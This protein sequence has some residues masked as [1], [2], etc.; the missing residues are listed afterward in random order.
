VSECRDWLCRSCRLPLGEVN[1][2]GTLA[3]FAPAESVDQR[4]V[5]R[6]PCPRCERGEGL[7]SQERRYFF[8]G[9]FFVGGTFTR[10]LSVVDGLRLTASSVVIRPL[11]ES[12]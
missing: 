11:F 6:V 2:N 5:A 3:L 12:R 1:E 7:V 10:S 8:G 9:S 4:G